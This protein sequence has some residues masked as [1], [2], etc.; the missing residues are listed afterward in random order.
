MKAEIEVDM[1]I[2]LEPEGLTRSLY[3]GDDCEPTFTAKDSWEEI[4]ERNIEY[5]RIPG[6]NE[7][8][9]ADLKALKTLVKGLKQAAKKFENRIKEFES[10]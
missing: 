10:K 4:I 9:T 1:Y 5:Y 2:E 8:S 7:I 3:L 6:S